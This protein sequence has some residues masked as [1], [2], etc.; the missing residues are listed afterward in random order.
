[1]SSPSRFLFS[2]YTLVVQSISHSQNTYFWIL[3]WIAM[4]SWLRS[5]CHALCSG[6]ALHSQ[7]S[8]VIF[9]QGKVSFPSSSSLSSLVTKFANTAI[10]RGVLTHKKCM[11]H[12]K[13]WR[14]KFAK[15]WPVPGMGRNTSRRAGSI[16]SFVL[17]TRHINLGD[18]GLEPRSAFY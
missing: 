9:G 14:A 5:Y 16:A 2:N 3:P 4:D 7:V 8:L 12:M 10:Q 17:Q 1:M 11:I 15:T 6:K 18:L 13:S